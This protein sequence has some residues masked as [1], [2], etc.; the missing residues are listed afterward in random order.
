MSYL[1]IETSEGARRVS[2]N[3]ERLSIG[4]L[5]YN[6]VKLPSPQISRQH[7]E[8]R[9]INGAWWIADL[10]STN[11][12]LF[13]GKRIQEHLLANGDQIVLAPSITVRYIDEVADFAVPDTATS[14]SAS[15]EAPRTPPAAAPAPQ[16][17]RR[18]A[19]FTAP[20]SSEQRKTH[21][22]SQS[23]PASSSQVY[24]PVSRPQQIVAPKP[25]SIYA[26]DEEPYMPAGM[27]PPPPPTPGS[28]F[29]GREERST[30]PPFS[31]WHA[32]P[33][34]KLPSGIENSVIQAGEGEA[35]HEGG[36]SP[37]PPPAPPQPDSVTSDPYRRS[38]PMA[39]ISSAGGGA[40]S[41]LLHVC[42]TCG[43]LTPPD[44]VYCQSCRHSIAH[45]CSTCRL[46]L[47]PIQDRCPRCHTPN[48]FSV[49]RAHPGR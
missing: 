47:L 32:G 13:N 1:E 27:A 10:N 46:N 23:F 3:G 15:A 41:K 34:P 37:A 2:L 49:R 31:G 24:P 33:L 29:P 14:G 21:P 6:D 43:Q 9:R 26:D 38:G 28:T 16:P 36:W 8:L 12:L 35:I 40:G 11:G 5:S 39:E 45:E 42:Q 22:V 17:V 30:P 48:E 25:R 19:G 18:L 44:A 20:E 7:A 4:R